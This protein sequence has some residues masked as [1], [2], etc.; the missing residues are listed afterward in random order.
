M[1][2]L[3]VNYFAHDT[4]AA[5]I[6]DGEI[7]AFVEEER[8]NRQKHTQAFP[9][10]SIE[11]CL[12]IAG[13]KIR[14]VD[15]VAFPFRPGLDFWR[16]LGR[17]LRGFPLTIRRFRK[18]T[19]QGAWK[20][21]GAAPTLRHRTGY[22]GKIQFIGHHESHAAS[23]F[24]PSPFQEAAILSIDGG[25][26]NVASLYAE[27]KGNHIKF[28]QEV[29]S[30]HSVGRVY[31]SLTTYLGFRR[32]SGEGKVMGLAAYGEPDYADVFRRMISMNGDGTHQTDLSFFEYHLHRKRRPMYSD[33][34][35]SALGEA[36]RSES[37]VEKR[38]KDIASSI[39][40]VTEEIC[41]DM[42]RHIH[43]QTGNT[44]LCLAGGVAM[45]SVMNGKILKETPI[46]DLYVQPAA[47]DSGGALGA[48]LY[49]YHWMLE[50]PRRFEMKH[51]YWGP[52]FS[53]RQIEALLKEAKLPYEKV[54]NPAQRAAELLSQGRIIGWFQG[55]MEVGPRALG[56]RSILADPRD[57]TMKDRVNAEVKHREG[58]RPF[59]PAI[60][61]GRMGEY[62]D[63]DYP[64]PFMLKVFDVLPEK[65]DV[66]PAVTHVDG[67]GR[68]QTVDRKENG[69]FYDLISAF[70]DITGVPVVLN[71]S[72]NVRGEPIVNTP[73]EALVC[74]C[75][76]GLDALFLGPYLLRKKL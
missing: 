65:R 67:S 66:I 45:N 16:N 13:I 57:P 35:V 48:A 59:A 22:Q 29:R 53:D 32:C 38:H 8:L 41:L 52:E 9:R 28:L 23:A 51:A 42:V 34:L 55:R 49:V 25:G 15:H 21:F 12:D 43:H 19:F 46:T 44:R 31:E 7:V 74:Y 70:D 72:F 63:M 47:A 39:Q 11:T 1:Y 58:F 2:I 27:G 14:D 37:L 33:R 64:A 76:T 24:Y 69:L 62:F 73:R 30:P 61:R 20:L 36:R 4:S 50:R 54:D 68:V 56:N 26:D 75:T 6:S 40:T 17:D 18:I 10:R 5:L 3:G 60:L 71:T